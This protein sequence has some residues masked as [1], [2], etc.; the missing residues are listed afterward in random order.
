MAM[1]IGSRFVPYSVNA[2]LGE[3]GWLAIYEV[4]VC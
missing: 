3:G 4:H 2:K 1:T